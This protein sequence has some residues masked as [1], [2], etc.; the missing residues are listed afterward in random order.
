MKTPEIA[1]YV[2]LLALVGVLVN[3]LVAANNARKRGE[4]DAKLIEV[5]SRLDQFNAV[6]LAKVQ[7]EHSAKLK[8]LEFERAQYAAAEER[9]RTADSANLAN[10]LA[11]L[12]P[13]HVISFLRTHDFSGIY[14]RDETDPIFRFIEL[15]KRPDSEFL[16]PELEALRGS[17]VSVASKLSRLLALKT[18]PRQGTFGSVLPESLVNDE[19]PAWVNQNADEINECATAFVAAFE[20]LVRRARVSHVG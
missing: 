6:E 3:A 19:R 15:S 1:L 11:V 12:D 10:L 13:D 20:D 17:L 14:D 9:R 5:K 8:T 4:L 2:G 7:A 18:H 16:E